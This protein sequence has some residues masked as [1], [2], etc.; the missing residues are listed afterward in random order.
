MVISPV[1]TVM[2]VA[3]VARA[4]GYRG[5]IRGWEHADNEHDPIV[6]SFWDV[7]QETQEAERILYV[8]SD[9]AEQPGSPVTSE[10]SS[11]TRT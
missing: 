4:A 9:S 8:A 5:A 2:L 6:D 7:S 10:S 1:V 11:A 3:L